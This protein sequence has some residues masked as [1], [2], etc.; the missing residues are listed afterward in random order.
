M[1]S[2]CDKQ[3]AY[4]LCVTFDAAPCG[5]T[6]S[7]RKTR[8]GRRA[9]CRGDRA[10]SRSTATHHSAAKITLDSDATDDSLDQ[11]IGGFERRIIEA[12]VLAADDLVGVALDLAGKDR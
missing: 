6:Q 4:S 10:G 12:G 3:F 8:R 11:V 9:P 2:F 7:S 5:V 1:R